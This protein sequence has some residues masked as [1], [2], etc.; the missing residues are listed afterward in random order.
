MKYTIL[1]SK[2]ISKQKGDWIYL[3]FLSHVT[4]WIFNCPE[5]EISLKVSEFWATSVI[6]SGKFIRI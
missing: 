5:R 4:V 3:N 6:I 2:G 1:L